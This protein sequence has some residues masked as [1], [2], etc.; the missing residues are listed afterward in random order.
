MNNFPQ[1]SLLQKQLPQSLSLKLLPDRR[2]ST[3]GGLLVI[4]LT[5]WT[6]TVQAQ[7]LGSRS[8]A[9]IPSPQVL[10]QANVPPLVRPDLSLGARGAEVAEL[11][12]VL[13]LL[14]FYQGN[15]DGNYDE[16]TQAGVMKFQQAAGLPAT[17]QVTINTWNRLFPPASSTPATAAAPPAS[18]PSANPSAS[19]FPVPPTASNPPEASRNSTAP[20]SASTPNPT[21]RP[22]ATQTTSSTAT[23]SPP[24]ET[25]TENQEVRFPLLKKGDRG[26]AVERLQTRLTT[27]GFYSDEIDGVFGPQTEE[28]VKA[29][30]TDSQLEPDG[31]VGP[32][33]WTVVLQ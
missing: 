4:V 11:Q 7:S 12:A 15:V 30:Q 27:L 16:A 32:A 26:P 13:R 19:A 1:G 20:P 2:I 3:L 21:P 31:V 25:R 23:A 28:A 8:P 5:G 33:T 14:G 29:L 24:T 17:G 6:A 18:T 22:A 10:A 9:P